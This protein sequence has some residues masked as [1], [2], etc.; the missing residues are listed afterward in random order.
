MVYLISVL[1]I[2]VCVLLI[3]IVLIQ[4][5]KGGLDSAFS[6][7]NQVMGVRKTTDFLEKATWTMG[8]ALVVLSIAS[9]AFNNP[10]VS[11]DDD[12]GGQSKMM[13]Q[14]DEKALPTAPIDNGVP[15][16]AGAAPA[17]AEEGK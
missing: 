1:V 9:S 3:L 10:T 2:I 13:E 6:T 14:I 12:E 8:I 11:T 7:N 15:I 17:P 4:N 16:P 5:P